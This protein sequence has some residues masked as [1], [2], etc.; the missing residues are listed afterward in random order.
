MEISRSLA[1]KIMI[2]NHIELSVDDKRTPEQY[3]TELLLYIDAIDQSNNV[4]EVVI[5]SDLL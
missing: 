4:N 5:N 1:N 3:I 2:D